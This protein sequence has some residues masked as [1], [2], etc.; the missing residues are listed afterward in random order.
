MINGGKRLIARAVKPILPMFANISKIQK[1][2]KDTFLK[3]SRTN[4]QELYTL[5]TKSL[6]DDINSL[7]PMEKKL[8]TFL[9]YYKT[10]QLS[11]EVIALSLLSESI[12]G[13]GIFTPNSNQVFLICLDYICKGH[14]F[15][16]LIRSSHLIRQRSEINFHYHSDDNHVHK[17]GRY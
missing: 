9:S 11:H 8:G 4:I 17:K 12:F 13:P 16:S 6:F 5:S 1:I 10:T 7:T 2:S 3:Q 14:F 15:Y